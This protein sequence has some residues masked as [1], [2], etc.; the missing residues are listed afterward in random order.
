MS[1]TAKGLCVAMR[2]DAR[3]VLED[4]LA[5]RLRA[6]H[7]DAA[8]EL[9]D[10]YADRLLRAATLLLNDR[11][12]AEDA[13]QET[14]LAAVTHIGQFR[15]ESSLYSWLY[16]IL[17]RWCRRQQRRRKID[18]HLS[19]MPSEELANVAD[20]GVSVEAKWESAQE[21][22]RM[23]R[24]VGGLSRAHREAI[25]LFYHEEFSI[26]EIS[27][28][29]GKPAGTVKSLLHRARQKLAQALEGDES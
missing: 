10:V 27:R 22:L 5:G 18:S 26:A 9:V 1:A 17:M 4:T 15:G 28:L 2:Q 11:Y 19:L 16:A 13:V 7:E 21:S 24:A 3:L 12:L 8:D 29:T 23:S 14:L 6:G 20:D 25:V